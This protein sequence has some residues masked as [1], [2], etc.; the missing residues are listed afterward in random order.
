MGKWQITFRQYGRNAVMGKLEPK[1]NELPHEIGLLI[2]VI[3]NTQE[4]ADAICMYIRGTLQHASYPGI[5]A[6]AGNLAYPMSPFTIPCGPVYVFHMDHLLAVTD[7][8]E[9]FEMQVEEIGKAMT[10]VPS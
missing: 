10:A 1:K 8:C 2:E 4:L 3:G 7:P 5:L 6:T 9:C